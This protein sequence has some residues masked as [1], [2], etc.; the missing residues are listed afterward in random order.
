MSE[1]RL[2]ELRKQV[3]VLYLTDDGREIIA[4]GS[5]YGAIV[6]PQTKKI[7]WAAMVCDN[8]D[9]PGKSKGKGGRPFLFTWPNPLLFVAEDGSVASGQ[10]TTPEQLKEFDKFKTVAC[11]ECAKTRKLDEETDEQRMKYQQWCR[12]YVLPEAAARLKELDEAAKKL[13]EEKAKQKP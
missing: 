12:R 9:C 2:F 7:A 4:P 6:D 1:N 10:P 3:P 13:L 8:P 5:Q 11:P